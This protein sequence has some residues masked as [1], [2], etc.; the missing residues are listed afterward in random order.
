M[1][2]RYLKAGL[3]SLTLEEHPLYLFI[4]FEKERNHFLLKVGGRWQSDKF[5]VSQGVVNPLT[6]YLVAPTIL[7]LARFL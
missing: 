1:Y 6:T 3:L 4:L 2:E 7:P 5:P